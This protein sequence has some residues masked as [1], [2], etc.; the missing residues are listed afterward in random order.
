MGKQ[1]LPGSIW[2]LHS[3]WFS[4]CRNRNH[5][6]CSVNVSDCEVCVSGHCTMDCTWSQVS[7]KLSIVRAGWHCTNHI[8]WIN[9]FQCAGRECFWIDRE[10]LSFFVFISFKSFL[11]FL[12]LL[13]GSLV[14][15]LWNSFLQKFTDV[16]KL[17]KKLTGSF[18][19]FE[20]SLT[21][22]SWSCLASLA[23][24]PAP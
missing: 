19:L 10:S 8:G 6:W 1:S 5:R 16:L 12:S 22:P 23:A 3:V 15:I 7:A 9:V 11:I 17:Y 13:F 24:Y 18:T 2:F 21:A 4:Q 14:T 20:A